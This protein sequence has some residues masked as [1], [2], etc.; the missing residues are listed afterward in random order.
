MEDPVHRVMAGANGDIVTGRVATAMLACCCHS[1][2]SGSTDMSQWPTLPMMTSAACVSTY[3][4]IMR[5][6]EGYVYDVSYYCPGELDR[7]RGM[8]RPGA[9][10][11]AGGESYKVG[12]TLASD[13]YQ[14]CPLR[15]RPRL[16][17]ECLLG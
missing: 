7:L 13:C 8:R 2:A 12:R 5:D 11:A 15:G 3:R 9:A 10:E 1:Y 17:P 14:Y 6:L 16:F 4:R